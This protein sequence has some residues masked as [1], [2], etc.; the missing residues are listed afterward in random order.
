MF[1]KKS[2]NNLYLWQKPLLMRNVLYICLDICNK[3]CYTMKCVVFHLLMEADLIKVNLI[4]AFYNLSYIIICFQDG[5][6]KSYKLYEKPQNCISFWQ[7]LQTQNT[8]EGRWRESVTITVQKHTKWKLR[9]MLF[10]YPQ[11]SA[12]L[13]SIMT[14]Q[15]WKEVTRSTICVWNMLYLNMI[16]DS[17]GIWWLPCQTLPFAAFYDLIF[18][19]I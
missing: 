8:N 19:Q 6:L 3:L 9:Y 14:K 2:L 10:G 4:N 11:S 1:F 17:I 12:S 18:K 16:I 5:C 13:S 7:M 15:E